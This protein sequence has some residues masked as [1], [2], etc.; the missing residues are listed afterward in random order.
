MANALFDWMRTVLHWCRTDRLAW[1]TI[2]MLAPFAL[3]AALCPLLPWHAADLVRYAGLALQ[4]LGIG[5][6]AKN[7]AD[8]GVL[9]NL[10]RLR[11][12]GRRSLASFPRW[13][14]HGKINAA[15]VSATIVASGH[16]QASVWRGYANK[17]TENA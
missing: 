10:P 12:L 2:V 6:V 5:T 16:V 17:S 9:F 3:L 11:D 13:N 8:K 14:T 7:L 4:L 15:A 1:S